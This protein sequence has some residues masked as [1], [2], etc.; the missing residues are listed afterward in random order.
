MDQTRTL[1]IISPKK[2][3]AALSIILCA[4]IGVLAYLLPKDPIIAAKLSAWLPVQSSVPQAKLFDPKEEEKNDPLIGSEFPQGGVADRVR[5]VAPKAEA[6]YLLVGLGNCTDC[7]T[8]DFDKWYSDGK[9][10]GLAVIVFSEGK[11]TDLEEFRARL[12]K[13]GAKIPV[14]HDKGGVLIKQI[15][16]YW[17]GRAYFYDK[18]WKLRWLEKDMENNKHLFRLPTLLSA[19]EESKT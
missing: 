8:V 2:R 12:K 14:V 18:N 11:A 15:N 3:I 1:S 9:Q 7:V 5:Q 13:T 4:L 6:G 17:S 16:N 10:N 19:I